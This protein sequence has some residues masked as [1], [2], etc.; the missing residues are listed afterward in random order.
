MKKLHN[1]KRNVGIIYEQI[2]KYICSRSIEGDTKSSNKAANLIKKYFKE[3]TQ[4]SK[5][6][7]LFKALVETR[8]VSESLGTSILNETKKACNYHFD[9][10]KLEIEKSNLI[11]ELNYSFGKG[12]IFKNQIS[13][14]KLYAT[15]QTLLNEWRKKDS[16][17]ISIIAKY[18]N[19]IH[20]HLITEDKKIDKV[21][22]DYSK[23][24]PLVYRLMENK[25]NEK[26]NAVLNEEQ[27]DILAA[28][29]SEDKS[30]PEYL[31]NLKKSCI[32]NLKIYKT[33]CENT[34]LL[35]SFNKVYNKIDSLDENDFSQENLKKF[36]SLCKLKEE[37]KG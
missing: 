14:Y 10:K 30:L 31:Y 15:I 16:F 29:I 11:K 18:Q 25:F 33:N 1:K 24:N 6:Y 35:E 28:V 7:K 23:V 12:V 2:I 13:D 17:D 3:G 37:I 8:G 21:E 22:E 34:V 5:E 36:L 19:K 32:N 20:K 26:Y 9:E 4:L 27:K